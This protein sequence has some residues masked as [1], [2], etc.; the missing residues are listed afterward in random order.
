[1][2]SNKLQICLVSCMNYS[3]PLFKHSWHTEENINGESVLLFKLPLPLLTNFLSL[4]LRKRASIWTCHKDNRNTSDIL[5]C[6][7]N[8]LRHTQMVFMIINVHEGTD[9]VNTFLIFN[10]PGCGFLS[11]HCYYGG[12]WYQCTK[13]PWIGTGN[14]KATKQMFSSHF[15]PE[16]PISGQSQSCVWGEYLSYIRNNYACQMGYSICPCCCG[17]Y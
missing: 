14:A 9:Y 6:F 3:P 8:V 17:E 15:I 12:N 2:T 7:V 10:T 13:L 4:S 11:R 16:K 5:L 1:M